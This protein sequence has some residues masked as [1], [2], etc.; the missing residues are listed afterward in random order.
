MGNLDIIAVEVSLQARA[1]LWFTQTAAITATNPP[2]APHPPFP[3][4]RRALKKQQLSLTA[5]LQNGKLLE[6]GKVV[7]AFANCRIC[8]AVLEQLCRS[9]CSTVQDACL[10][11]PGVRRRWCGWCSRKGCLCI[12]IN[13]RD[14]RLPKSK[15]VESRLLQPRL[16]RRSI[17]ADYNLSITILGSLLVFA[18]GANLQCEF[19]GT[20][21]KPSIANDQ[22]PDASQH[23]L[24]LLSL[25]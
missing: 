1:L 4:T 21:K 20:W 23:P 11:T 24:L 19:V 18:H 14:A 7:R 9:K 3:E 5:C 8:G 22:L 6:V 13:V 17:L 16:T 25:A 15:C 10:R 2:L 12:A